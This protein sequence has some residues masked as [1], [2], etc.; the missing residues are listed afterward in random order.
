MSSRWT[1]PPTAFAVAALLALA[2]PAA[3]QDVKIDSET[4]AGLDARSIG[5]AAMSGRVAAIDAVQGDWLTIYVGAASGGVWKSSNGGTTFKPVFDK[6]LQSIGAIKIDP[7]DSRTVWVGTGEPWTRNS[8]SVGDGIYKST[9]GGE[10]WERL[11][12]EHTERIARIAIDPLRGDTVF[13]AATGHL[14]NAHPDRGIYRTRD[15]GKTWSKVLYVD[16]NTGAAD[17]AIDPSDPRI[18]YAAMWQFRR[19]PWSFS[20]G[21]PGSNLYKSTD[22]GDTWKK[23][24]SGLPE[25]T[26]GRIAVTV[27][28][29]RPERVYAVVEALKGGLFRSDDR[30]ETWTE[31]SSGANLTLR[32]FYFAHIVADPRN[33]DHVYKPGLTLTASEDGG[34]TF[35][36]LAGSTHSDHHALWINPSRPEQFILGTDGG[37]YISDDRG[38]RWRFLANLPLSQFYHV[39]YDMEVPYNVYGGLQDNGSWMG[40]SQRS[41]GIANRNWRVLGGGDGFWAFV[42][43]TEPDIAYVEY[44][45][46]KI[47]R[48]RRSTGESKEIAPLRRAGEPEYRFNWNTPIHMSEARPG[49]M[50]F[51]SQFLFRSRDR[52]DSWETISP[53]LTT[54]DAAKQQ[55]ELSGGISV[56]N[57]SAENHCTIFTISESSKDPEVVWVGTDDGNVQLTRDG[58]KTWT[59]VTRNLKGVPPATWVSR[60]TASRHDAATAYATFD[61]HMTGDMKTYAFKT[62]DY[63]RTWQSLVTPELSGFAHV[64][65]EDRVNP[66]LLFL[67][68]E[69][70][71]FLSVDGGRQWGAFTP[72]LPKVPVRDIAI[73]PRESALI[74]ATHG[75]GIY[76]VDD[77]SPLRSLTP[78]VLQAD[79]AFLESKP[80]T[81][82]IPT[83]EQRF[84]GDA[85]FVGQSRDEAAQITYYLKKRHI[86]G[87]LKL[88]ISDAQGAVLATIPGGKRRGINRVS[89]PMRLRPPKVPPAANL[90]PQPF[91][92]V[93]PRVLEGEY[94]VKLIK[95]KDTFAS[96]VRLV[97]DPRSRH[98]A[99]DRALQQKTALRLYGTL[100]T[101]T[102]LA[103]AVSDA[104][105]QADARAGKLPRNEGVR[106]RLTTLVGQLDELRKTLSAT[107]EGRLT[108]EERLREKLGSLYG[109]INGH[110][111]RPTASQIQYADVLEGE[112]NA[113]QARFQTITGQALPALNSG[114]T[115]LKLDPIETLTREAWVKRQQG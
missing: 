5:P 65:E 69:F 15:G 82:T 62:T 111:G 53:D 112:L 46:G 18:V 104:R 31:M 28:P 94:S 43:P 38:N 35:T 55:Q 110:E 61:G 81:M 6:H 95:G 77:L 1:S 66:R 30:G 105:E 85:D 37:V 102:W 40:P 96:K 108:G 45:G 49:T 98:T 86:F 99:E 84:D 44:Q 113:A 14:W 34:R 25:G 78:E 68:T 103:D 54:N 90:V 92:F 88:E 11:G 75:R 16:E 8:V 51:G 58:G 114:L 29:A 115:R 42:D 3:A 21:G 52:G 17:V 22:G 33:P 87:D 83:G 32:P 63:G 106:K 79:A 7:S 60:I 39:S 12:L 107:R 9:D 59:N 26:L 109:A 27:S 89:W 91:S 80:S 76:I 24:R 73:H 67:G 71:L 64:I 10:N 13:I 57:S 93:G 100:E 36:G 56:D 47:S 50:Y 19:K 101:L 48:V 41:G 97:P 2:V 74:L 4:F 23:L 70:G 20:S 72:N